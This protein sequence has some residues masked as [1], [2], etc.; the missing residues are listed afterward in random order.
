MTNANNQTL[1]FSCTFCILDL[2]NI[3]NQNMPL[4]TNKTSKLLD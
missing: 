2:L 3:Q 1:I 4:V